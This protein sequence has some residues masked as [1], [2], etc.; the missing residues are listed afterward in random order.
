MKK[1]ALWTTMQHSDFPLVSCVHHCLL[2][3]FALL[4]ALSRTAVIAQASARSVFTYCGFA[5]GVYGLVAQVEP[6]TQL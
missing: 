1:P 6:G 3:G 5:G 4:L 2:L